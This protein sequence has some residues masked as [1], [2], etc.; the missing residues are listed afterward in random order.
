MSAVSA[1][2]WL[3]GVPTYRMSTLKWVLFLFGFVTFA[4]GAP[5]I[6]HQF[7]LAGMVFLPMHFA[8]MVAA[9]VMGLRG[10]I[11]VALIS[12]LV[13]YATSGMPPVTALMPMTIELATYALVINLAVRTFKVPMLISLIIA[14]IV[15]RAVSIALISLILQN[16]Q[17]ATQVHN[18]FVIALPG[19]LIQLAFVP[20][21]SSKL[22]SFL[23]SK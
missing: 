21:I 7:G 23:E 10:G 14:M 15:G 4:V 3:G 2:V 17:L 11:A 9:I 8:I 5:Y 12:P 1:T 18:L 13:S 20:L 22:M 6:C 16:T 19:I